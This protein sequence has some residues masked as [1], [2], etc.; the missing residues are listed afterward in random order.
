MRKLN[1]NEL[2]R[3]RSMIMLDTCSYENRG[4]I[5]YSKYDE[6]KELLNKL[7]PNIASEELNY[8]HETGIVYKISGRG[9]VDPFILMAHYDVVPVRAENW[10]Q[11]PFSAHYDGKYIWGRG[12]IDT[13]CT[14]F[15]T[16][17][18]VE[19]MLSNGRRPNGDLYICFSGSEEISGEDAPKIVEFLENKG[20]RP[21]F[22]LDEGGAVVD[23][24]FPGLDRPAALIGIGEK[25]YLD[26]EIS[27]T[28]DGGHSSTPHKNT[29][30]GIV[31]A[32]AAKLEKK[33]FKPQ[34]TYPVEN[35]IRVLGKESKG[36][37]S[38]LFNNLWLF[39]PILTIAFAKMGGEMNAL[40]RTTTAVTKLNGADAFNIIPKTSSIGINFRMLETESI[41]TVI[42]HVEKVIGEGFE[43][44]VVEA[45]EASPISKTDSKAYNAVSD[46]IK[47]VW[48]D[49]VV[50]PYLMLGGS[51]SRHYCKISNNVL[52][53][54][55]LKLNKE[56]LALIHS[57]N[58]RIKEESLAEAVEFY[59]D[60]LDGLSS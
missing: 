52:R 31:A 39:K 42:Q 8:V 5:D 4:R 30:A 36:I 19:K 43:Y 15:A 45:R 33:Q 56:E 14:V 53:F 22:V 29:S 49:A 44:R 7:Y 9:Q 35:M 1:K 28:K 25:G 51:D 21:E 58:E 23:G 54:C 6:F 60:L 41:K 47:K 3:F 17:E 57:P 2:E 55:A 34:M 59:N 27:Y 32:A 48:T 12:T 26:L 18:S 16:M 10:E 11:P 40:V 46:S 13:K 37:Y 24:V 20:V 38:F 50:S